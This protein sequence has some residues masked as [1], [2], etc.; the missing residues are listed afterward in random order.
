MSKELND[1]LITLGKLAITARLCADE[2]ARQAQ[3][4]ILNL[5]EMAQAENIDLSVKELMS[6]IDV[7]VG[8]VVARTP[9]EWEEIL[10]DIKKQLIEEKNNG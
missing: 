7:Q 5:E 10:E 9:K 1:Y 2:Q 4:G 8:L 6:H 3:T